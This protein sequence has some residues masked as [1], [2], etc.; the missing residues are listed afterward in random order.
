MPRPRGGRAQVASAL[1]LL[2]EIESGKTYPYQYVCFRVTDYRSEAH[3]D[4]LIR[5]DDLR[6][7]LELFARRVE[8]SLPALP[9]EQTV[10]PMLTLDEVS[11]RVQRLDEDNFPLAGKG[12]G[13]PG[14]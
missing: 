12:S 6:H 9:I 7:D 8:R 1:K 4:L 3:P 2:A 13:L 14:G 11:K 10:E 5:G